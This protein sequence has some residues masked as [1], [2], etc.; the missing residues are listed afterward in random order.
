MKTVLET[1]VK[2]DWAVETV[3]E[4]QETEPKNMIKNGDNCD[5]E[6]GHVVDKGADQR[7]EKSEAR[8]KNSKR[9]KIVKIVV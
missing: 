6:W 9:G 8:T 4:N 3:L 1:R 7:E 5:L 2:S